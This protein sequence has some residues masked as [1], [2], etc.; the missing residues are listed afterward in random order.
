MKMKRRGLALAVAATLLV[1][2]LAIPG[3]S[4]A[5][6]WGPGPNGW[7]PSGMMSGG[8]QGTGMMGGPTGVNGSGPGMMAG[9]TGTNNQTQGQPITLDQALGDV[10]SYI[11]K[12]GNNDLVVDELMEFQ[13]NYYAIV[14]EKSTGQGAFELL[15]NKYTGQVS[16]EMGPNMMWNTKYGMHSGGANGL[17]GG[18]MGG[19]MGQSG[20]AG[21]MMSQ[22]MMS[23]QYPVTA[24]TEP[25]TV[26]PEQATAKAQEWLSQNQLGATTEAPDQFP[27]YYTIHTLK[28]GKVTGMLS[29]NG[30][31]GQVWFH[32]WHGDFI[33]MKE[34]S[35]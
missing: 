6:A 3:V 33:Q 20:V 7:G 4:T 13:Y 35:Q 11:G 25:M 23:G 9:W 5:L 31:T 21:G 18:M 14:K 22:G 34:I 24:P 8:V 10:Q 2:V 1:G 16:P 15:V 12:I 17:S 28:D 30:Y 27:G 32:S 26:T 29:V 19:M